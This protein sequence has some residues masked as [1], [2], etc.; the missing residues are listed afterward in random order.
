MATNYGEGKL[1]L[2]PGWTT[3]S[4]IGERLT[5]SAVWRGDKE[6]YIDNPKAIDETV[7]Q[8]PLPEIDD[9]YQ[10]S[11]E[12][13]TVTWQESLVE[14]SASYSGAVF[15]NN[16]D[17]G[18]KS[19]EL[20]VGIGELPI[21]LHPHFEKLAGTPKD[22]DNGAIFR[23]ITTHDPSKDNKRAYFDQFATY[24]ANGKKA[25]LAGVKAYLAPNGARFRERYSSRTTPNLSGA[26]TVDQ[27][28][29]APKP[30]GDGWGWLYLGMSYT[31]TG[32]IYEI[33]KEWQ[34]GQWK[35]DIYPGGTA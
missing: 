24:D 1:T 18:Q 20:D 31:K 25:P 15:E 33:T 4:S 30:T 11:L 3:S 6:L 21:E 10:L 32:N 35:K 8:F 28:T 27:P 23:H 5:L 17:D 16:S 22:P 12:S 9:R 14:V 29:G 7:G 19:Y 26:G 13:W 2:Q 34:L